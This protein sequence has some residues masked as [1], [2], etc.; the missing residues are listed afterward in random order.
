MWAL[1]ESG[2]VSKIYTHPK[3]LTIGDVNYPSNIFT[4][5]SASEL[6]AIGIYEIVIDNTNYKNPEY[7]NNT[8]Q[9]FDFADGTVTASYGTATARPLDDVLW[10]DGDSDIPAGK[11]VGDVK[12]SGIRQ[13]HIDR[14]NAQAAGNLSPTDW[15]VV[16]AAEGGTAVPSSITTKR[17][18]VRTKANAMCTQI[19]NAANVDALAALYEY[20]DAEPPVRPLGELPTVD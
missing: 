15:M 5:W 17:A 3:Q 8:N 1:V 11:S 14:I 2:S 10:E 13:G 20:N 4:M 19:T 6:E 18:A 9:T 16:R 7:Y 12:T